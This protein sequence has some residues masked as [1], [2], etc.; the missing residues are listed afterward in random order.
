MPPEKRGIA[1]RVPPGQALPRDPPPTKRIESMVAAFLPSL[2]APDRGQEVGT[3]R[4]PTGPL[5]GAGTL[6]GVSADRSLYAAPPDDAD[7]R[8]WFVA[9]RLPGLPVPDPY[10]RNQEADPRVVLLAQ[11]SLCMLH[12]FPHARL[13]CVMTMCAVAA[14]KEGQGWRQRGADGHMC[15]WDM[16]LPRLD[17]PHA[18]LGTRAQ[19]SCCYAHRTIRSAVVGV[20]E[21]PL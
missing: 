13:G 6:G 2:R 12:G 20:T 10:P 3:A 17:A 8:I 19:R 1:R 21:T 4:R 5:P 11:P 9:A 15:W 18:G 14:C 7:W 16:H